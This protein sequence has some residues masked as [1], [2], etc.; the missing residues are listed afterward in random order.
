M[1]CFKEPV[2]TVDDL[3]KYN[4]PGGANIVKEIPEAQ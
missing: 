1:K 4:C 3:I 2:G